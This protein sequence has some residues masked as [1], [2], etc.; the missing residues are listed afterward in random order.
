MS[1]R[2]YCAVQGR[3]EAGTRTCCA[4]RGKTREQVI[5]TVVTILILLCVASGPAHSAETDEI[6]LKTK[7][8]SATVYSREAQITRRGEIE[9]KRGHCR[10]IC[11]DLPQKFVETSLLV[12]GS[13]SAKAR[14]IGIDLIRREK[15]MVKPE[16]YEE[17]K[18]QLKGVNRK[19]H[20]L[21]IELEALTIRK[22]L[23]DTMKKFSLGK[24]QDELARETFSIEDWKSLLDFYEKEYA[25]TEEKARM[26]SWKIAEIREK[27]EWT[28]REIRSMEFDDT[29]NRAV[30]IDCEVE[31]AGAMTIDIS[32]IVPDA[33]WKP[34]YTIRYLE[35]AGEIELTY[36]AKI[37][38]ATGE[39]WKDVSVLLSTAKPHIGAAPPKLPPQYLGMLGQTGRIFGQVFDLRTGEPLPYA[40]VVLVGTKMGGMTLTDG[41]Y[42]IP[43]VPV[44]TYTAKAMMMGYK[45]R[46]RG[47]VALGPGKS[48]LIN[49]QLEATIVGATQEIVVGADFPALEVSASDVS[50]RVKTGDELHARGGRG[51]EVSYSKSVKMRSKPPPPPIPYIEAEV[52]ATE[53]AANLQIKK[54]V[55]LE[56]GSEPK[57]SLVTRER[58]AGDLSLY[59]VPS[60]SEHVYIEGT[61]TNTLDVP[62]LTGQSEVYIETRPKGTLNRVTNFVGRE[63]I[64][65]VASGQ[66]FTVHLGIDQNFKVEYKL[67]RKKQLTKSGKKHKKIRYHYLITIESY[68]KDI[69]VVRVEDR[70]PVS[71]MKEIKVTDEEIDPA[72]DKREENGIMGWKLSLAPREKTEIRIAY[73]ITFPSDM[74]ES[75]VMPKE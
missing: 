75:D 15:P 39:D 10:I 48:A 41:T 72:P 44:G 37:A 11:E 5:I 55:D 1:T 2:A 47:P 26:V 34:A 19:Y 73:T 21:D 59:A 40:N 62:L 24:A 29:P 22:E 71:M 38:Q 18:A 45:S 16:R 68:K 30:V 13:G 67:E 60:R 14:I 57:R 53:F 9:V 52:T 8:S 51:G 20:K 74:T 17:L 61:F 32:Y 23:L 63:M 3:F 28:K 43:S 56:T 4:A 66:E 50:H 69:V 70:I 31:S 12:E 54:P 36:N 65:P 25:D 58:L 49:F 7:I 46:Q 27:I 33:W 6:E 64:E 35:P 42:A